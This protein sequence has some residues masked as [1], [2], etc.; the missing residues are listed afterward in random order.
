MGTEEVGARSAAGKHAVVT[1]Q[2]NVG[3]ESKSKI[4]WLTSILFRCCR[5]HVKFLGNGE[6]LEAG[7][8]L[9]QEAQVEEGVAG[10]SPPV[11]L[12]DGGLEVLQDYPVLLLLQ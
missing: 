1:T 7:V 9:S 11:I 3:Y 2:V 10:R 6:A 4:F 8:E 12:Q 5:K